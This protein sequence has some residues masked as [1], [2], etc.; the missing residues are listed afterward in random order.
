MTTERLEQTIDDLLTLP[1]EQR[2]YVV[3]RISAT[4]DSDWNLEIERRVHDH[5]DGA[6]E[7]IDGTVVHERLRAL[8]KP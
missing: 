2:S 1:A 3:G 4:L 5:E 6:S 7:A 8:S